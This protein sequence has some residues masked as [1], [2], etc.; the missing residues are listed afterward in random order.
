MFS[1][2]YFT[3]LVAIKK[4]GLNIK[5]CFG[6]FLLTR[7]GLMVEDQLANGGTTGAQAGWQTPWTKAVNNDREGKKCSEENKGND[8]AYCHC[9]HLK[10]EE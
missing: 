9:A 1:C 8:K 2:R 5:R 3:L 4:C 10:G 6:D 7:K